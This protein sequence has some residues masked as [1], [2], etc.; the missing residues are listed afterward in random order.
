MVTKTRRS[1]D[2]SRRRTLVI[3]R[4]AHRDTSEG[5]DRDNGLSEKG[6]S[7]A[8]ELGKALSKRLA[9]S[10]PVVLSSPKRRC[11]ETVEPLAEALGCEVRVDDRLDEQHES[12][13][14]FRKRIDTFVSQAL[15]EGPPAMVACSHGDWIPPCL[16]RLVGEEL[17]LAK[18][19]WVVIE[20]RDGE[21]AL[22]ASGPYPTV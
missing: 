3:V 21:T 11:V 4:H 17:D 10:R 6:K 9:G 18:G 16:A 1:P 13:G 8:K 22:V 12:E 15:A 20:I 5:R 19:A 2:V 7:Q 14:A